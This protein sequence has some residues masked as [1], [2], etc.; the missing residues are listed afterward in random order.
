MFHFEVFYYIRIIEVFYFSTCQMCAIKMCY[1]Q[2]KQ[3]FVFFFVVV[4]FF[5]LKATK[6]VIQVFWLIA[7]FISLENFQ[8]TAGVSHSNFSQYKKSEHQNSINFES[9]QYEFVQIE[10]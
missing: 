3:I 8:K 5:T 1:K 7:G 2:K 6:K 4:F 10:S 9:N